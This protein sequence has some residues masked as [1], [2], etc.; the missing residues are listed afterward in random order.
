MKINLI[1]WMA[2]MAYGVIPFRMEALW[3]DAKEG[4]VILS[5]QGC[6]CP[7]PNAYVRQG[8][9]LIPDS[10]LQEYPTIHRQQLNLTGNT[11]FDPFIF[12]VAVSDLRVQG[13]IIGVDTIAC[14]RSG[15]EFAVRYRVDSWTLLTYVPQYRS[16]N[17]SLQA[18]YERLFYWGAIIIGVVLVLKNLPFS[19]WRRL[20]G[21][22]R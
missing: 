18:W 3:A 7:C 14:S 6:G 10:I 15:C 1:I 11:P 21:I 5:G 16:W 13:E 2:I 9:L 22:D 8:T 17:R 12:H 19:V 4:E 20:P